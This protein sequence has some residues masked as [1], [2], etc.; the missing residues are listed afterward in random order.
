MPHDW[1]EA[2]FFRAYGMTLPSQ[3]TAFSM[4][5]PFLPPA[6][7][8]SIPTTLRGTIDH[9]ASITNGSAEGKY[10]GW[11]FFAW[12]TIPDTHAFFSGLTTEQLL[13]GLVVAEMKC[14]P[15]APRP[16]IGR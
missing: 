5:H 2:I 8:P 15:P 1:T 16:S 3:A 14:G 9:A 6:V 13:S 4:E 10:T 11:Q 12:L 7:K